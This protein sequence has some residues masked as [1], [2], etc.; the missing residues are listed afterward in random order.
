MLPGA[1]R[2]TGVA[3]GPVATKGQGQRRLANPCRV[4]RLDRAG[5]LPGVAKH[6]GVQGGETAVHIQHLQP[7]AAVVELGEIILQSGGAGV[8]IGRQA[9]G[10]AVGEADLGQATFA[11]GVI[12]DRELVDRP[13]Q[14]VVQPFD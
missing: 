1:V 13:D 4:K 10:H 3:P 2:A 14:L 9:G 5:A 7:A 12:A 6:R 11:V 8:Q